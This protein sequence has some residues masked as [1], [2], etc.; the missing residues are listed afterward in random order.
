MASQ[1]L[2]PRPVPGRG[3]VTPEGHGGTE[4]ESDDGRSTGSGPAPEATTT[5][6]RGSLWGKYFIVWF[7]ILRQSSKPENYD[8]KLKVLKWRVFILNMYTKNVVVDTW[9]KIGKKS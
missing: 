8:L 6:R 9:S 5:K 3:H 2:H 1:S 7:R 4:R